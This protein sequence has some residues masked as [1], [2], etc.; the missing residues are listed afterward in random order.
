MSASQVY[1]DVYELLDDHLDESVDASS[2]ERIALL[3]TGMLRAKSASPARIAAAIK[4]LGLSQATVES[5]ERRVR[6]IENDP[7]LTAATCIHPF[8]KARLAYG[9][10]RELWLILDPTT[11]EDRVVMVSVA[12]WYRGRALPLAWSTWP[13]NQPLEGDGFWV[14]IE[15][16][17]DVVAPLLPQGVHIT[18]L[19]DRAF[20]SALFTDMLTARGWHYVVRAQGQT[21]CLDRQERTRRLDALVQRPG[22]RAKLRAQV[23][24]KHGW[25]DAS[26]RVG[27]LRS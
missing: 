12:V 20:G 11:Q 6:R 23:F 16:L 8:A 3:V 27:M 15:A 17:L 21:R 2:R 14:R 1:H 19:A 18:W 26:V 9:K 22:R 4:E 5:I 13:A 10:P 24:K 7:E 25:R